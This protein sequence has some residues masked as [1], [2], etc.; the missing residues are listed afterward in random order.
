MPNGFNPEPRNDLDHCRNL[1]LI[2]A[3][4]DRVLEQDYRE[5]FPTITHGKFVELTNHPDFWDAFYPEIRAKLGVSN[6]KRM[7]EVFLERGFMG[8]LNSAR[9]VLAELRLSEERREALQAIASQS[10]AETHLQ[11][12]E[13]VLERA[14]DKKKPKLIEAQAEVK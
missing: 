7:L 8:D 9:F 10:S 4:Q 2:A 14:L 12:M 1:A 3:N 13:T 5:I 11:R 6:Y